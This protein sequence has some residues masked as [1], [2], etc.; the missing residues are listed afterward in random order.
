MGHIA[1]L[2]ANNEAYTLAE[3][4]ENSFENWILHYSYSGYQNKWNVEIYKSEN[5]L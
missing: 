1:Q 3:Y 5:Q 2:L 4:S